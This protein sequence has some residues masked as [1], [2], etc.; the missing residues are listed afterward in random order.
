MEKFKIGILKITFILSIAATIALPIA[1][2]I[3]DIA[4]IKM[5]IYAIMVL[6]P[7]SIFTKFE[8]L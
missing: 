8:N 2:W 4:A 6:I 7:F 5:G 3:N 1:L